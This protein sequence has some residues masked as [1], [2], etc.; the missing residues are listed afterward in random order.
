MTT[1]TLLPYL[2]PAGTTPATLPLAFSQ[3]D[4]GLL[5]PHQRRFYVMWPA[6]GAWKFQ[7]NSD[8]GVDPI[9]LS[10]VDSAPGSGQPAS[11]L[12]LALTQSGLATAVGGDPLDLG[13]EI[14]F[15]AVNGVQ[16]WVE[17]DDNTGVLANDASLSL[18]LNTLTVVPQ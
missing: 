18:A 17:F 15:G 13:T 1:P 12:K 2:D 8:P 10:V 4:A 6:S 7:A 14:L 3:D 9:T 11:A 5:P 16:V